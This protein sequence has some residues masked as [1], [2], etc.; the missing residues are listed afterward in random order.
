M[1]EEQKG[2][3]CEVCDVVVVG[4]GL[5][6]L[7]SARWLKERNEKLQVL[8]LEAKGRVGGR[9]LTLSL[10]AANGLD[11]WDMGGQWVGSSQ[12]HI[13]DLIEELG[14]ELYPQFTEGKKIHHTGGT[15]TK[16]STYTS[17]IPSFSP[18]VLLDFML[19]LW[20]IDRLCKSVCVQN[21]MKTPDAL[22]LDSMTLQSYMEKHIWTAQLMEL[23]E[24]STR[25]VFGTEPSQL[26]FLYFL[27]YSTAAGGV[28]RLLE[29]TPG[30]AQEFRVKGGAQQ[31]SE[32]VAERLGEE[33]VR[34]GSAVTAIWQS[35]ESVEVKTAT[36]TIACKAVIVTCPPH[37]AGECY[38]AQIEYR[39]ALPLERQHLAQWMPVGHMTKF[40]I[41]YPTAFWKQKGF[42]GEIVAHP[43]VHC[44]FGVT[45]DATSPSGSPALVG[46]I[47]GVQACYWNSREMED[48]R[49]A[50]VSSL[51][52]YLG[53]EAASYI[54]YE[55]KDWA[56]EE[57][58]GGCPVNVMV[59][60][61]LTFYH[62]GLRKPCGRIYWAGTETATEWCGYLSGAVQSGQ[63]AALEVL[64]DVSPD[65][66][67]QSELQ[68]VTAGLTRGSSD[69]SQVWDNTCGSAFS[70][71]LLFG[72][73]IMA[74]TVGGAVLLLKPGLGK[75]GLS[76]VLA[77]IQR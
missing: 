49:D 27:M 1:C 11:S 41:T 70:S 29:A 37:M 16:I 67:S 48:R 36:S 40:I 52:K 30:S 59:P 14:L 54:H 60:G 68:E 28:M 23:L 75:S 8:V 25:S 24:L 39:P 19:F 33:R 5:S 13:M 62:P 4:G 55:E 73:T 9:T 10:P 15:N 7:C 46:F 51:V 61:M 35:E 26:S 58:N 63:R 32:Q 65:V 38:L 20:R 3:V 71:R 12:T 56:K 47:A 17:S 34:L 57:Y 64:A 43:S 21:P 2:G 72:L 77:I 6:G 50:V 66:L 69:L 44:P 42:S 45:F 53:P 31:L 22:Q 76:R 74:V 18:L